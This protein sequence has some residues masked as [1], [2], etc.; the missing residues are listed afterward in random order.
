MYSHNRHDF[1]MKFSNYGAH[2]CSSRRCKKKKW[3]ETRKALELYDS[4]I[5]EGVA[6]ARTYIRPYTRFC[7]CARNRANL[8][9]KDKAITVSL[10]ENER[11]IVEGEKSNVERGEGGGWSRSEKERSS[12]TTLRTSRTGYVSS[13]R[14]R[15]KGAPR[16]W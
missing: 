11:K 14:Y 1:P 2:G 8:V 15:G 9:K 7:T 13:I 3:N 6:R 4:Q 12:E 10:R 16:N 5:Y